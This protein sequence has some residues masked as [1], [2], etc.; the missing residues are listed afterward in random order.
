[1]SSDI[2]EQYKSHLIY[3]KLYEETLL[4]GQRVKRSMKKYTEIPNDYMVGVLEIYKKR[5]EFHKKEAE[6][7]KKL[8]E[9]NVWKNLND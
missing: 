5:I 1:M 4:D 2:E 6:K 9:S 8:M 3:V 7:L